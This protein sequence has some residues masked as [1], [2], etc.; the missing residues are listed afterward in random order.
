MT[1]YVKIT[2]QLINISCTC[3]DHRLFSPEGSPHINVLLSTISTPNHL[4]QTLFMDMTQT[5][6]RSC[7]HTRI[8]CIGYGN[9]FF[10]LLVF[11]TATSQDIASRPHL[12]FYHIILPPTLSEQVSFPFLISPLTT[13]FINIQSLLSSATDIANDLLLVFDTATAQVITCI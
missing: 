1:D 11:D 4:S 5:S 8:V 2:L 12:Y 13:Q 6:H 3:L 9:W 7:L 10:L